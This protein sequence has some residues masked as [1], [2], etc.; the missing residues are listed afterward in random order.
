RPGGS[1]T[2]SRKTANRGGGTHVRTILSSK[3]AAVLAAAATAVVAV[4]TA[5]AQTADSYKIGLVASITGPGSFLGDP[6]S[7]SAQLAVD[8]AN[9]AGGINGKKI[10][11]RSEERR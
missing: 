6:F 2:R 8:R 1:L 10:E 9:V 7:K 11:L 4:P 3:I 5:E